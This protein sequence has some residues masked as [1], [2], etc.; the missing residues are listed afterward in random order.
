VWTF[1]RGEQPVIGPVTSIGIE[2][3]S[4]SGVARIFPPFSARIEGGLLV[5]QDV[6]GPKSF[7]L[8][9]IGA[10][11]VDYENRKLPRVIIGATLI[12]IGAPFFGVGALM[13][14]LGL[15]KDAYYSGAL[16]L[17]GLAGVGIGAGIGV[18]GIFLVTTDPVPPENEVARLRPTFRIGPGGASMSLDF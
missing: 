10:V 9:D 14:G 4:G 12:T 2:P 5:V 18:P 7:R 3:V 17:A 8:D 16:I 6:L 13:V 15:N 11:S 1:A